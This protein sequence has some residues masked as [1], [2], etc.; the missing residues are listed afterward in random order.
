MAVWAV[1]LSTMELSPH[2]L[3]SMKKFSRIWSLIGIPP[4]GGISIQ[5]STSENISCRYT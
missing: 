1:S 5:S 4:F 2:S 3:T